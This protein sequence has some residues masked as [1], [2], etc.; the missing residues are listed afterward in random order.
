[1][2]ALQ[3]ITRPLVDAAD[4]FSVL[5]VRFRDYLARL[6]ESPLWSDLDPNGLLIPWRKGTAAAKNP[7]CADAFMCPGLYLFGGPKRIPL[8]VGMTGTSLWKRL[9][10]RYLSGKRCQC[11]L[12]VDYQ[13]SLIRHGVDGFPSDIRVW[14]RRCFGSSTAR[15]QGAVVFAESGPENIWFTIIPTPEFQRE[16]VLKF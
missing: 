8:Y 6:I 2:N 3:K 13:N 7:A 12:A 4:G 15:L 5:E 14:Y 1:M 9:R 11:Q 16:K 10:S